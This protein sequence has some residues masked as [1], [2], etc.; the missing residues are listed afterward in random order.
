[1][2]PSRLSTARSSHRS[3]V[4]GTALLVIG[5]A[6]C[7][8]SSAEAP[9]VTVVATHANVVSYWNDIANKTVNAGDATLSAVTTPATPPTPPTAEEQRPSYH[10]DLA[11]V[12]VAIYDAV[13][14]IDGRYQPFAITATAAS[15]D[16]SIDA[17]A[18]AAAYGVLR[19]F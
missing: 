12:H 9:P 5:V 11:T 16:A 17:A 10:V 7:G 8:G 15:A 14:A 19:A 3:R 13:S 6:G 4:L 1:M 18:S 2:I